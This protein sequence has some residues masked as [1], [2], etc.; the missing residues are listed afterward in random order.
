VRVALRR[1]RHNY[2]AQLRTAQHIRAKQHSIAQGNT[3]EQNTAH[4]STAQPSPAQPSTAQQS[5][6]PQ[7]AAQ[8]SRAQLH[9]THGITALAMVPNM[10]PQHS[11]SE[12]AQGLSRAPILGLLSRRATEEAVSKALKDNFVIF[13]QVRVDSTHCHDPYAAQALAKRPAHQQP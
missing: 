1:R 4:R 11:S 9:T 13:S 5:R 6:A 7:C 12:L 10:K 3:A 2:S 8:H